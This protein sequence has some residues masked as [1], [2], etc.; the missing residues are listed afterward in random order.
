MWNDIIVEALAFGERC[1]LLGEKGAGFAYV[2]GM[3][4]S[5]WLWH[6]ALV[7]AL[8]N[9]DWQFNHLSSTLKVKV[10]SEKVIDWGRITKNY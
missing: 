6:V 5:D 10:P 8:A 2:I 1:H 4:A 7:N 3:R 9:F